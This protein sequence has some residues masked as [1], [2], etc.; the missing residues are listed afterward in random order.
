MLGCNAFGN[1][2]ETGRFESGESGHSRFGSWKRDK[3]GPKIVMKVLKKPMLLLFMSALLI[4]VVMT[5]TI[6]TRP[7]VIK[8]SEPYVGFPMDSPVA[9]F[10]Q[11]VPI[12]YP[13]FLR[14]IRSFSHD[15]RYLPQ[16]QT[17]AFIVAVIF[18]FYAL[19]RYGFGEG[20]A[21]VV[22]APMF[23]NRTLWE[24]GN[25][26]S[27]DLFALSAS[28]VCI[29]SAFLVAERATSV[30]R[31][32]LL[33]ATV[34][35]TYMVRGDYLF[36]I[37]LVPCLMPFLASFRPTNSVRTVSW[38]KLA[39]VATIAC[40]VPF[41]AYCTVRY[42]YVKHFGLVTMGEQT[43]IVIG[44]QFLQEEDVN[45]LDQDLRPL[46]LAMLA[47][48]K[49]L[50]SEFPRRGSMYPMTIWPD[51]S[52]MYMNRVSL[53]AQLDILGV[54]GPHENVFVQDM[55]RAEQSR[56][57]V[58]LRKLSTA[59]LML[60]PS[61]HLEYY[62]K[63]MMYGISF[64]LFVEGAV[65]TPLLLLFFATY[66]ILALLWRAREPEKGDF[67]PSSIFSRFPQWSPLSAVM[68][69]AVSFFLAKVLLVVFVNPMQ[70]RYLSAT[71]I[72]IPGVLSAAIYENCV[73]MF[74]SRLTDQRVS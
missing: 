39:V 18:L 4:L 16:L 72:F 71:S 11:G 56:L 60:H 68:L 6:G 22:V 74:H 52:Y 5:V 58:M 15:F 36:L 24:F 28:I 23:C 47:R 54:R 50:D 26:V 40:V 45:R 35:A 64:A 62:L 38:K 29:G 10:Q 2:F 32:L 46:A 51:I 43:M 31:W 69:V 20:P 42:V 57:A 13:L 21:L 25:R 19:T 49:A 3:K 8:E 67:S 70:G 63:S 9:I 12:G 1:S 44:T 48:R 30:G 55:P 34:F 65:L 17:L 37:P 7:E 14:L 41:L 66:L 27:A 59:A 73:F 61:E 33:A 53:P